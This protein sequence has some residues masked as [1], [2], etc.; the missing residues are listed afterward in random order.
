VLSSRRWA[1]GKTTI[2]SRSR[3]VGSARMGRER[4]ICWSRTWVSSVMRPV[5]R[6]L[7]TAL[8]TSSDQFAGT[9]ASSSRIR[10]A[11][12]ARRGCFCLFQQ[13]SDHDRRVEHEGAAHQNRLPSSMKGRI[14]PLCRGLSGVRRCSDSNASSSVSG[15]DLESGG[16]SRATTRPF[17]VIEMLSPAPHLIEEFAETPARFSAGNLADHG[18]SGTSMLSRYRIDWRS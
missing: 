10:S 1:R 13:P 12:R 18:P 11:I 8:Q 2:Q 4:M 6:A 9:K 7:R 16:T 17:C 15:A 3:S 5:R 14:S